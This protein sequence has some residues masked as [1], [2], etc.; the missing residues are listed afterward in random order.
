MTVNRSELESLSLADLCGL[1]SLISENDNM[2]EED[3]SAGGVVIMEI[4]RRKAR[5]FG[6]PVK[7][8]I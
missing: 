5:V 8:H 7:E 3:A 2:T 1:F 6:L 4:E